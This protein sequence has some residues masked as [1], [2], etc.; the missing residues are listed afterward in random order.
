MKGIVRKVFFRPATF[1]LLV[2]FLWSGVSV[3]KAFAESLRWIMWP[4]RSY[5]FSSPTGIAVD[6][7]GNVY[8]ADRS[9]HRIQKFDSDGNYLTQW[10]YYGNGEGQFKYP[11]GVAV[12]ASGNVYVAD[13]SNCRIQKFD[14]DGNW[15]TQWGYFGSG[16]GQFINPSGIT[17]DSSGNVYVADSGN[18]RIQKFDSDGNYLTQWG[19]SGSGDGQFD[20]PWGIAVD[21]LGNVYVSDLHNERIQKF[22]SSGGYLIQWGG[23]GGGDGQFNDP[24]GLS[25]DKAGNVYVADSYNTR[26]Q[27]FDSNGS[28]L[29]QWGSSGYGN[30]Q[31]GCP[32]GVAVDAS[33]NVYTVDYGGNRIQKFDADG[34]YLAQWG[35]YG[36]DNGQFYSPGSVAVDSSV[37]ANVYVADSGNHRI[38]KFDSNGKYLKQWGSYGSGIG[39]FASPAG[40]A[41]D[42]SGNV[43]VADTYNDRIQKFDPDGNYLDQWGYSGTG[44][45]QFNEPMGVAVDASGNVYVVDWNHRVQ[46]FDSDGNYLTRWGYY[47]T[48]NGQF[49]YPRGVA[50]DASGNVYV[51]DTNNNRIQKFNSN[52]SF[53]T[54]W[55][56]SGNG[57]GQFSS[58]YGVTVDT[59]GNVY[60]ADTYLYRI[61]KFDSVGNYLAKWG[62]WGTGAGQFEYP[63]DVAVDASGN[64]YVAD[65]TNCRIQRYGLA[66]SITVSGAAGDSGGSVIGGAIN[67]SIYDD[68]STLGTCDEGFAEGASIV[69]KAVPE[70][71]SHVVWSGCTTSSGNTCNVTVDADK[72]VTASFVMNPLPLTLNSFTPDKQSPQPVYGNPGDQITWTA[73]ASGGTGSLTYTFRTWTSGGGYVTEQTGSSNTWPWMPSSPGNY[74]IQVIVKDGN[75]QQVNSN[76]ISYTVATPLVLT[77]FVSDKASPQSVYVDVGDEITWTAAATGGSG[78]LTYTFRTWTNGGGYVTQQSGASNTW[79]WVASTPGVYSVQVIVTDSYGQKVS[80]N[81]ISYTIATPLVLTS[82]VSDKASPQH[83]YANLGDEIKWT[84]AATGGYGSLTYQFRTWTSGSGAITQQSGAS[85][86]WSW[87]PSVP[88]NYYVQ[89][90]VMDSF[91]QKVSSNWINYTISP[92]PLMFAS[93]TPDKASPQTSGTKITW[94]ASTTGGSGT[95]TYTFRTWTSG[96]GYVVQQSGASNTWAW[97]P[98]S[99]GNYSAQVIVTDSYGQKVNSSWISYVVQ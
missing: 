3:G 91:V 79:A 8:V 63:M 32:Y 83:A 10:G 30:N 17:V 25:V 65:S 42:A 26:I 76:W 98:S 22:D 92:V 15:L 43:Y 61:Q 20:S 9:D 11:S 51:A 55:G 84:A 13:T 90:I 69:L 87:M 23:V 16:D 58:P 56:S 95:V 1:F 86:N 74:S 6:A 60:V 5:H 33:G 64:I 70:T 50:V 44:N 28:Y 54:K 21:A 34:S 93:F 71:G 97:T 85:N 73:S 89:V 36:S 82:F 41:V 52:G 46:K 12:D 49:E 68:G 88:G 31:F 75:G 19:S 57:N 29:F 67:C 24:M 48:G 35:N 18:N 81:W 59:A 66:D 53:L 77:S 39:Q 94:N 47:G 38:Q 99:P 4:D 72:T 96:G 37:S 7:S 27:K 80:S 78:T 2:L 14:P 45:G 40:V 62:S